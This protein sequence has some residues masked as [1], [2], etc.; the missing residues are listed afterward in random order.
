MIG[1]NE[2]L[3]MTQREYLLTLE[4]RESPVCGRLWDFDLQLTWFLSCL[5][6]KINCDSFEQ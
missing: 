3:W 2:L 4:L 6:S 5:K 1:S